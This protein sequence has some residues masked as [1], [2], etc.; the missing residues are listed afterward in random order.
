MADD[1][2][3]R[4]AGDHLKRTVDRVLDEE[5][6][7][8]E[9]TRVTVADFDHGGE[10]DHDYIEV[11]CDIC[12]QYMAVAPGL[13]GWKTQDQPGPSEQPL[14]EHI[15]SYVLCARCK[16]SWERGNYDDLYARSDVMSRVDDLAQLAGDTIRIRDRGDDF[17]YEL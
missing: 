3:V 11:E 13:D 4:R 10:I 16:D 7:A 14:R 8:P 9:V 6:Q 15:G 5:R 2:I 17:G 12:D 1:D